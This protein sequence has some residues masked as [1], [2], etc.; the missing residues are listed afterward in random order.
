MSLWVCKNGHLFT[1]VRRG[2]KTKL[3]R[4]PVCGAREVD[5]I[6]G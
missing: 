6:E 2:E 5:A 4:C 1:W 3:G